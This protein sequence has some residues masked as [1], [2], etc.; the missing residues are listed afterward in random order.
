[1]KKD[2]WD[3][4]KQCHICQ[5]AGKPNEVIPKAP[6][7]PIVV[8]HEPFSK[9]II[10]CVGP[11]PKTRKGNQ[12]I[13]TVLCPTT[14]YPIAFPLK[15]ICA[16]N[17]VSQLLKVFTTYGFPKE[18]QSDRGTN[19]TSDL[20]H[21]TLKELNVK[22]TLA[23]PYYPQ[24]QGALERHHQ[25]LKSLLKKFC[26]ERETN[27]DE[28][29]DL[30][31]FVIREVPN[32]SLGISPFE[33]LYGHK[34][35][36]PLQVLKDKLLMSNNLEEVTVGQYVDKLKSKFEKIH[37]FA[38]KNLANSQEVM[39][40]NFDL[41]CTVRKFK[42]GDFVLAYFPTSGSSL[43]HKFSGPY[44]IKKCM[45]NNNYIIST[46]DR[47]KSTQ[48]VH[49]N[50]IKKYHGNPPVA[51]HCLSDS[52]VTKVKE[53]DNHIVQHKRT[54]LTH[55]PDLYQ[56]NDMASWTD[57]TNQEISKNLSA[58]FQ[59]LSPKQRSQLENLLLDYQ[60]VCRDMPQP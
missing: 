44:V 3:F 28:N 2:V 35:R 11:L 33:M 32:E 23:L 7:M 29:L 34:V 26:M 50:L 36:G 18:I 20:F 16:R 24:S 43:Q 38:F 58:H 4:V 41:K 56:N 53:F 45:N 54:P 8:P 31:L 52:N 5:L 46:P 10:D 47:R 12:Y 19:F 21:N 42:E 59:H 1:M 17:I 6:L 55:D 30:L 13:L 48:L 57:C 27:W 15:N 49:V 40:R 60:D 14:R 39:K 25:T 9:I 22:H 51:L 37:S